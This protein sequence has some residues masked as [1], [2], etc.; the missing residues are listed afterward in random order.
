MTKNYIKNMET[1]KIE[2]HF[3]KQ[4]YQALSDELKKEI[5]SSYLFSGT[6][7]AWVS[8]GIH[9]QYRAIQTAK[10]LGFTEEEKTGERLTF[11]E[12]LERKQEKAE[13]RADRYDQY[14]L[15]ANNRAKSLQSELESHRGDIAFFTQPIIA[16][17]SGSQAFGNRRQRIYD[18]YHKGFEE[19]KKSEYFQEKA[20]TARQTADN[21]QVKSP[22]YLNNRIGE[23]QKVIRKLE[24]NIEY[25]EDILNK[26]ANN[27]GVSSFYENKTE[28]QVQGYLDETIDK[29]EY[30]IDKLGYFENCMEQIKN[31]LEEDGR[32]LYTKADLK[33]GY[34]FQNYRYNCWAKVIRVN[35]K[36]ITATFIEHP[37]T[38][39]DASCPY[40]EIKEVKIPED[41]KDE[42]GQKTENPFKVG[43]IVGSYSISGN[44]LIRAFQVIK[45][46]EK[47]VTIRRIE[48]IDH[49]PIIDNFISEKQER[50]S[51]KKDRQ[52]NTVVNNGDWYLYK[53]TA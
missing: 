20:E 24:K 18:R 48:V 52:G 11:A 35:P 16:G 14:A 17:H 1:G 21:N 47:T 27:E 44:V 22:I 13:H 10:K 15:N 53:Y 31:K 6:A 42:K 12:Q 29:L 7:K 34:L 45:L 19:Y 38:G 32:K 49:K 23:C 36:T 26:K 9:N 28:E 51:V 4:E 37:L 5:Q 40:A 50:K 39:H 30:E 3:S 25:Y 43:D 2:L 8:R 46:T 41:W 33:P